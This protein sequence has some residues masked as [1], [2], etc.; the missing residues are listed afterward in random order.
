[1][2]ILAPVDGSEKAK[3]VLN[4][5]AALAR[6]FDEQVHVLHVLSRSDFVDLE[7]TNVNKTGN[8]LDINEVKET[9][10][11]IAEEAAASLSSDT[12]TVGT[13]GE[14]KNEILRYATEND[15]RYIVL[16]P[17]KRSPA[18]KAIFGSVSQSV[19]LNSTCPV[20]IVTHKRDE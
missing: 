4:E 11:E 18:G 5:A 9:A 15:A 14:P 2:V 8:V 17:R 6:A 13:M 1:M 19:L 7:R 3:D 12:K 10:K 16:G 20:V